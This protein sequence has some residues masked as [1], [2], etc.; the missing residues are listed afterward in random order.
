[1]RASAIWV[2]RI[3]LAEEMSSGRIM[4][5]TVSWR[6]SALVRTS[7]VPSMMRLPLGRM[8]VTTAATVR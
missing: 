3:V 1:M 5:E 8:P 4:P 2:C 6:S 7:W